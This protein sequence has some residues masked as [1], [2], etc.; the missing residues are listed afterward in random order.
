MRPSIARSLGLG[1]AVAGLWLGGSAPATI[2]V[3]DGSTGSIVQ[4]SNSPSITNTFTVT[5][6]ADV[7][8]V[9]TYIRNDA[10]S[11]YSPD[12]SPWAGQYF[13]QIAGAFNARATYAQCDIFYIVNP[14]PGTHSI[15]V[16]DTTGNAVSAMA[17]QV[18]TLSGVDTSYF[19]LFFGGSQA[20]STSDSVLLWGPP[21][22]PVGR[23]SA[24]PGGITAPARRLLRPVARRAMLRYKPRMPSLW[25]G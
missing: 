5:A 19:P 6:G 23:R 7:L 21:R 24:F 11:D 25:A 9:S 3:H 14:T 12:L 2:A 1:L 4:N 15:M 18:Y 22:P 13:I 17:M 10:G 20:Y 16:T 8:V